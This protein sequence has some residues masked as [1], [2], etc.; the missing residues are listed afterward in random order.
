M[1]LDDLEGA[2]QEL[3]AYILKVEAH[4]IDQHDEELSRRVGDM[5]QRLEEIRQTL[6]PPKPGP[7]IALADALEGL[8]SALRKVALDQSDVR[9]VA[10]AVEPFSRD[11]PI[12]PPA[13]AGLILLLDQLSWDYGLASDT[14]VRMAIENVI[15]RASVAIRDAGGDVFPMPGFTG[16]LVVMAQQRGFKPQQLLT[17]SSKGAGE[18]ACVIRRAVRLPGAAPSQPVFGVS[19]GRW[20]ESIEGVDQAARALLPSNGFAVRDL[21]KL[22]WQ[23]ADA[24]PAKEVALLRNALNRIWDVDSPA[25]ETPKNRIVNALAARGINLVP[26]AVGSTFDSLFSPALFERKEVQS[27]IPKNTIVR[28]LKPGLIDPTGRTLQKAVVMVSSGRHHH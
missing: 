23:F 14:E 27:E 6:L 7:E 12:H 2:L 24:D 18:L 11:R 19:T 1:S 17:P 28:V 15:G 25:L 10:K 4:A 16:P 5:I 3:E 20:N 9:A 26:V 13:A 21:R 8:H 22:F